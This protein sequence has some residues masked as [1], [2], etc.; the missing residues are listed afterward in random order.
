MI[1]VMLPTMACWADA[2]ERCWGH[3][4]MTDSSSPATAFAAHVKLTIANCNQNGAPDE[5][6]FVGA[7]PAHGSRR[8]FQPKGHTKTMQ[9]YFFH[10]QRF[11]SRMIHAGLRLSL[12]TLGIIAGADVCASSEAGAMAARARMPM[13]NPIRLAFMPHFLS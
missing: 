6:R 9:T 2:L 3:S 5:V 11:G 12:A 1:F 4:G 13:I 10:T 7:M 8:P